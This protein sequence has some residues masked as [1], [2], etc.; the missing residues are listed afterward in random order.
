MEN[1]TEKEAQCMK[2][3]R[4]EVLVLMRVGVR[5]GRGERGG[6]R[7]WGGAGG[8]EESPTVWA[9]FS[10]SGGG[11]SMHRAREGGRTFSGSLATS[12]MTFKHIQ[13]SFNHLFLN[14]GQA[15]LIK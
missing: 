1:A 2:T 4:R 3:K 15:L 6:V 12:S 11:L 13:M 7:M 10:Y 5:K 8:S 14:K 9:G